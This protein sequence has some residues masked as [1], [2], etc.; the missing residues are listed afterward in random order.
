MPIS[1]FLG[2]STKRATWLATWRGGRNLHRQFVIYSHDDRGSSQVEPKQPTF[3]SFSLPLCPCRSL[4]LFVF[5]HK[6]ANNLSPPFWG[7]QR[8]LTWRCIN[9]SSEFFASLH[10]KLKEDKS[11]DTKS[12]HLSCSRPAQSSLAKSKTLK[13]AMKEEGKERDFHYDLCRR[14]II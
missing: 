12:W 7:P 5:H 1:T 14:N 10:P 9:D 13:K 8:N 4:N 11:D 2:V 6:I 3:S